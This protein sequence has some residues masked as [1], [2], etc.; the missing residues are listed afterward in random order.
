PF[1]TY[2]CLCSNLVVA[3][4]H[5]LES[6]PRRSEPVQDRA[7]IIPSSTTISTSSDIGTDD[8]STQSITSALLNVL[9]DRRPII[10]QREDGFEKRIL[11]RCGRCKLVLGYV[12]DALQTSSSIYLLPGGLVETAEMVKGTRPE[13]PAWAEQMG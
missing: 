7:L 9:P 5:S 2:H 6:L 13:V 1:K 8:A 10:V 11:L 12:M 4:I 3:T